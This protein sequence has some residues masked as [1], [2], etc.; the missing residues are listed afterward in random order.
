M[1]CW[2]VFDLTAFIAHMHA[3]AMRYVYVRFS[4]TWVSLFIDPV[5]SVSLRLLF[6]D[7]LALSCPLEHRREWVVKCV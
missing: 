2:C 6:N 4:G 7:V 1:M 5:R 3:I